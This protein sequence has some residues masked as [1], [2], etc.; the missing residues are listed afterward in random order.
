MRST[1]VRLFGILIL[2]VCACTSL[3]LLAGCGS[4]K[5]HLPHVTTGVMVGPKPHQATISL[6]SSGD[7]YGVA[8]LVLTYPDGHKH[9]AG[10]GVM[11]DGTGLGWTPRQ[12]PSGQYG[13]T[14]YAV[15]TSTLHMDADFPS[16][17]RT[18]SNIIS[19]GTFAI[20]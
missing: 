6:T 19:S 8:E 10:N 13:Y 3:A 7:G 9:V 2:L 17:G 16:D 11:E 4:S 20:D 1:T 5:P 12:L 18:E 14:F 15:P